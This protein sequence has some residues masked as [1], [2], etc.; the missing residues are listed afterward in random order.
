[1][2]KLESKDP[3]IDAV[4][5]DQTQ[6]KSLA[7]RSLFFSKDNLRS[8]V[9]LA[10]YLVLNLACGSSLQSPMQV[11]PILRARCSPM[12]H[13]M[14]SIWSSF[15]RLLMRNRIEGGTSRWA[16][17]RCCARS[18]SIR[19]RFCL[20]LYLTKTLMNVVVTLKLMYHVRFV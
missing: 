16:G 14:A 4:F 11:R 5:G 3:C 12:G 20:P 18:Y 1:M 19:C 9:S 15:R 2:L 7:Y 8:R 17:A 10:E 13:P 6:V